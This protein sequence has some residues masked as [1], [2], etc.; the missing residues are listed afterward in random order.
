MLTQ[1]FGQIQD[2]LADHSY[3]SINCTSTIK[4][5]GLQIFTKSLSNDQQLLKNKVLSSLL[6]FFKKKFIKRP[7]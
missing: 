5:P 3:T 7:V 1:Q 6:I 2:V 4:Q